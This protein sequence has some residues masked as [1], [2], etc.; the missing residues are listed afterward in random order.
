V[1]LQRERQGC[2]ASTVLCRRVSSPASLV[3]SGRQALW[4]ESKSGHRQALMCVRRPTRLASSIRSRL[5]RRR[6]QCS[7]LAISA[8]RG[9]IHV[10]W[11]GIGPRE[12]FVK[13]R[14]KSRTALPDRTLREVWGVFSFMKQ[15][16]WRTQN[17]TNIITWIR[18]TSNQSTHTVCAGFAQARTKA[19]RSWRR[20]AHRMRHRSG[21]STGLGRNRFLFLAPQGDT[22]V[23]I[24]HF[25]VGDSQCQFGGRRHAPLR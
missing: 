19:R 14:N 4:T 16:V 21:T 17:T 7:N 20:P 18:R 12:T 22:P 15:D 25:R 3:L 2:T 13:G 9:V 24:T 5:W 10:Y 1:P 8:A 11:G 6:N 23:R